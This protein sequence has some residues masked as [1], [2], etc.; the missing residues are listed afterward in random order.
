MLDFLKNGKGEILNLMF[1]NPDKKYYLAEIAKIL[2]KESSA[3]QK[4]V[5]SFIEGGIFCDQRIGNMR[6]FWLNKD[7]QLYNEIK[8]IISKTIG[9]E[10]Q[11]KTLLKE[12]NSVEIAFIFGSF[13]ADKFNSNSDLDLFMIGEENQNAIIKHITKLEL[14][15]GRSINYHI[16]SKKEVFDKIDIKNDFINN[17][18]NRKIIL[19]KGNINEFK[20]SR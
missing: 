13:A 2:G 18:F 7:Y 14:E 11:L 5:E 20:K 19:L 15:I 4:H 12:I 16:Y 9:V 6:F 1:L 10:A 3:Y 17:I 8:N